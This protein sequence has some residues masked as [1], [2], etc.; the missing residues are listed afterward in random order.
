MILLGMFG[1]STGLAILFIVCLLG[2]AAF[3]FVNGFHDTANAVATVIYTKTLKPT[4]A[5]MWSGFVNFIGVMF[6]GYLF[7]MTVATGIADLL[8]PEAI[9][10]GETT[11]G[12][13]IILAILIAAMSWNLGTWYFGIPCSSSHTLVGS[14]LGAAMAYSLMPDTAAGVQPN[15]SKAMDIGKSLLFSPLLGFSMAIVVMFMLRSLVKG[16]EIFKSPDDEK[17][18]PRWIKIILICTCTLVSFFHGSNDGQKGIGLLMIVL[19]CFLPG[20]YALAPGTDFVEIDRSLTTLKEALPKPGEA[21]YTRFGSEIGSIYTVIG[22][23]QKDLVIAGTDNKARLIIRKRLTLLSKNLKTIL[24][25]NGMITD[26]AKKDIISK[27]IKTYKKLTSAVPW[28]AFLIVSISLG[29][30]TM[31]GWKRIVVTIGEKIGKRHMTFAEGATAE[32]VAAAT[33]GLATQYS[34]P[35]STTHIL[36]SGVA[37]SMVASKGVKNLQRGTITNIAL[38]WVLTLPVTIILSGALYMLFRTFV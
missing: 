2:V 28:W 26:N 23:I 27:Q 7:G 20:Q 30:G 32:L 35:V 11:Q 3:E 38:A 19:M 1:L 24:E 18:T 37:G 10:S 15:W 13:A 16:K 22:D 6:S 17:E 8:P 21:D 4:T 34:L 31:I 5:V 14:I 33:I 29:L 25:T 36:S 12:A 9:I